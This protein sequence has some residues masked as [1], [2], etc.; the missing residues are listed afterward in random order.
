MDPGVRSRP[1]PAG[2]QPET[3]D[4]LLAR[5]SASEDGLSERDAEARRQAFGFNELAPSRLP[6]RLAELFR[7]S[8]NPLVVILLVAGTASAFLGGPSWRS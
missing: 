1:P 5:L 3:L 4:E 6:A 8:L 2:I 7:S